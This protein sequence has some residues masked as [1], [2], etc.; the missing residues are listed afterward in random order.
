LGSFGAFRLSTS[1]R[2]GFVRPVLPL[3]S[4][5]LLVKRPRSSDF[6]P[7]RHCWLGS[8]RLFRARG[9]VGAARR[10]AGPGPARGNQSAAVSRRAGSPA[11]GI[12]FLLIVGHQGGPGALHDR[13]SARAWAGC[14]VTPRPNHPRRVVV[15]V[16]SP[17]R[18]G[19]RP[20][21]LKNPRPPSWDS[22]GTEL[23]VLGWEGAVSAFP[24]GGRGLWR[25]EPAGTYR[26][27][28]RSTRVPRTLERGILGEW[29]SPES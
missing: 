20:R 28:D 19:R 27:F 17:G 10:T 25:R 9:R 5:W 26:G 18:P 14:L 8:F 12:R 3:G 24:N 22:V 29:R 4:W 6:T 15:Q 1:P 2:A 21:S 11:R 7:G 13:K 23:L 16:R